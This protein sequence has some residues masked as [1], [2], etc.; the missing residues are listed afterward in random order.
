MLSVLL[1]SVA[2]ATPPAPPDGMLTA[3]S[4]GSWWTRTPARPI[5]RPPG[6]RGRAGAA[7]A[8][9]DRVRSSRSVRAADAGR[10]RPPIAESASAGRR[11]PAAHRRRPS[12]RPSRPDGR[13][14]A[15]ATILAFGESVMIQGAEALARDLGPVRVDAAVGRHV[16]D[17]VEILEERAAAGD[18]ADTVIV[19]L[20]NNGP[21][22]AGQFDAAMDALRDVPTGRLGQ[23]P[24][25]AR[26]G[27][28]QQP[29]H[30]QRRG[31]L[32]ERPAGRLVRRHRGPPGPL[33]EGRL[34]P[35]AEGREA[36]RRPDRRLGQ[37]RR[38]ARP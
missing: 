1:V 28:A 14:A 8:L 20:G 5:S 33:L 23:R 16:G 31:A 2:I 26:L 32:S 9:A 21:F 4:T 24:R 22:R 19:Q 36:L 37:R 27:G 12:R 29:D 10:A 18:L 7:S 30:R 35:A 3:R 6:R 13:A 17:G 38:G 15:S 11:P 34:P 25:A